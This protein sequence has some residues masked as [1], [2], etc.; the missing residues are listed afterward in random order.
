MNSPPPAPA[1][2]TESNGVAS[3]SPTPA[4]VPAE[5]RAQYEDLA[6]RGRHSRSGIAPG[7]HRGDGHEFHRRQPL[8]AGINQRRSAAEDTVEPGLLP[9][10][11]AVSGQR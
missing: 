10:D 5:L 11:N 7:A 8:L 3:S 9:P 6:A 1:G 4:A 2:G